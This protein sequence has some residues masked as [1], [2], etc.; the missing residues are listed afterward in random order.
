MEDIAEPETFYAEPNVNKPCNSPSPKK[1]T[2]RKSE[3]SIPVNVKTEKVLS[4]DVIHS[5]FLVTNEAMKFEFNYSVYQVCEKAEEGSRGRLETED[6]G[7]CQ[8]A[9]IR[10]SGGG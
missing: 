8:T 4:D 1:D 2:R 10:H 5:A 6:P 3:L 9:E 7:G